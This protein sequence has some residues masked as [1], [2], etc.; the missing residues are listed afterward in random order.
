MRCDRARPTAEW[1]I[2]KLI[3]RVGR[4]MDGEMIGEMVD[5]E[6]E[7]LNIDL[8]FENARKMLEIATSDEDNRSLMQ[9]SY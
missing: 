2:N 9:K 5:S 6:L 8:E 4:I 3:G 7:N 1:F